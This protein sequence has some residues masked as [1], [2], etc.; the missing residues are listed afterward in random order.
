MTNEPSNPIEMLCHEI[1]AIEVALRTQTEL[2]E[3]A[4]KELAK[5][6][7]QK[8]VA[9]I[10]TEHGGTGER[11]VSFKGRPNITSIRDEVTNPV[12]T[13]LYAAPVP[14]A[15]YGVDDEA[16]NRIALAVYDCKNGI[17]PEPL[18]YAINR[19]LAT[20]AHPL[21]AEGQ[22]AILQSTTPAVAVPTY[23]LERQENGL[24]WYIGATTRWGGSWHWTADVNSAMRFSREEDAT[25][26]WVII[27]Q[28]HVGI[29]GSGTTETT[30]KQHIF[31]DA[32]ALLQASTSAVAVPAV[33]EE[34]REVMA[35]LVGIVEA[36]TKFHGCGDVTKQARALLQS[37]PQAPA[38]SVVCKD[39]GYSRTDHSQHANLCVAEML[40]QDTKQVPAVPAQTPF[41]YISQ[42]EKTCM[43][44]GDTSHAT[45]YRE[46]HPD[47]DDD[48]I[49]LYIGQSPE[50]S[51]DA[52]AAKN[53]DIE[54]NA[55]RYMA[56]REAAKTQEG[57]VK[58]QS[59]FRYIS[60]RKDIDAAADRMLEGG[61]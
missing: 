20:E 14:A 30:P 7:E 41:C 57:L 1:A 9:W 50:I 42:Y 23:L 18:L 36:S 29:G 61:G 48:G 38:V 22:R 43:A 8:P 6:R 47:G 19:I 59:A 26:C 44:L 37:A 10:R 53:Y 46:L 54:R 15:P 13:P 55:R 27:S 21:S 24:S 2:K 49:A 31:E 3:K 35:K 25:A 40:R 56:L 11:T 28:Y 4:E 32:S 39:C 34:W 17:N 45:V 51:K 33:P 16:A 52:A 60:S 5:L 58:L 12:F